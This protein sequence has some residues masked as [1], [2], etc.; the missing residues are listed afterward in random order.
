MVSGLLRT[1]GAQS[2]PAVSGGA[3]AAD[4]C[5][6]R[7][8]ADSGEHEAVTVVVGSAAGTLAGVC[9]RSNAAAG[10]EID[11]IDPTANANTSKTTYRRR[12][13]ILA[14]WLANRPLLVDEATRRRGDERSVRISTV[15]W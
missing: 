10:I 14:L 7:V 2:P 13:A 12:P 4:G 6:V 3:T 1:G 15:R 11:A 8:C 9:D 5:G